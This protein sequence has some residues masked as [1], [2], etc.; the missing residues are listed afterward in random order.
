TFTNPTARSSI[1]LAFIQLTVLP[2]AGGSE[3]GK[4]A[5]GK[6]GDVAAGDGGLAGL[7]EALAGARAVSRLRL[8]T[9]IHDAFGV[10]TT[11]VLADG[12]LPFWEQI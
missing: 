1:A 6:G 8:A 11:V 10:A 5:I 3:K 9:A 2:R 4:A 12:H 7:W